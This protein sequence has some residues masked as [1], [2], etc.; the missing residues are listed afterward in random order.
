M[1][2]R[3][4]AVNNHSSHESHPNVGDRCTGE[5]STTVMA[6]DN[7]KEKEEERGE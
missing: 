1:G 3:T 2:A 4:P 5:Y 7:G 6:D